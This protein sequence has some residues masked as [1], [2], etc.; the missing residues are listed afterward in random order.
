[1]KGKSFS[2]FATLVAAVLGIVAVAQVIAPGPAPLAPVLGY[3][4]T[5]LDFGTL[6]EGATD[7]MTF[8]IWNGGG[9]GNLTYAV[10]TTTSWVSS[11]TPPGGYSWGEWDTIN[12]TID[13]T[14]LAA[15]LH[16][17][18][19]EIASDGGNGTV[20]VTVNVVAPSRTVSLSFRPGTLNL[21][22][23]GK[24][25][26]AHL[27]VEGA[28]IDDIDVSSILLQD[29]LV[30][31]KWGYK[32]DVLALKFSRQQFMDTVDVGDSMQ[33]KITGEWEDGT[34]FEAYDSIRVIAPGK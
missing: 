6:P 20:D 33:V 7:T 10:S 27:S 31:E 26:T 16:T 14:G 21:K 23:N 9:S 30:P 11:I 32:D 13:T 18:V 12:V 8:S 34:A 25:V 2:L 19:V 17:G 1:M 5:S 15:G 4:P 24:W 3:S 29:V 28:S 22:S